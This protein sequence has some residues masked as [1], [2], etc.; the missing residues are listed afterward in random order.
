[1]TTVEY[2]SRLAASPAA[3][4]AFHERPEAFTLLTPPWEQVRVV[5]REGRGIEAGVRVVLE[6][7]VGPLWMR[8][9][10]V[11]ERLEPGV[12]FVDRAES[13]PFRAWRHVH[14]VESDG[15][16]AAWLIDRI[17]YELPLDALTKPVAGWWVG[18]K[19]DAMF[20]YRHRVTA[21]EVGAA[22]LE[23]IGAT[24]ERAAAMR[25]RTTNG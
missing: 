2:R 14:R 23:G 18:R 25:G 11:H 24:T 15:A 21:R 13:G 5:S 1:M 7:R 20:A 8:W 4:F 16:G 17:N 12:E 9:A 6:T 10:A 3:V 22:V 19:L